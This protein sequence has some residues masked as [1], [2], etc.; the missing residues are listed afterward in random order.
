MDRER[1]RSDLAFVVERLD[2]RLDCIGRDAIR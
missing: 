2:W 1:G